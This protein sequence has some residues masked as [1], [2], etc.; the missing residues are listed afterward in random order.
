MSHVNDDNRAFYYVDGIPTKG[1]WIDLDYIDDEDEILEELAEANII[2]RDEDENP[3]YDGDLLVADAEGLAYAFLGRYGNFD[4]SDFIEARDYCDNNNHPHA[5]AKAYVEWMGSW[6]DNFGD[7]YYG[8]FGS[9]EA[10]AEHIIE[11]TMD[12]PSHL[13]GYIDYEKY[14]RDIFAGDY[15]FTDGY[16]FRN[17]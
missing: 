10:F 11:E 6:S 3:V 14:A 17:R 8:E 15:Y 16:V 13:Q 4:L 1:V 9:E 2:G 7:A 5:A 12:V